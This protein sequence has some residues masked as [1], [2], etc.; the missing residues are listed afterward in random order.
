MVHWT[1]TASG[2]RLR[3]TPG[4]SASPSITVPSPKSA[5]LSPSPSPSPTA[6]LEVQSALRTG[7]P[8]S[9]F[10]GYI[11]ISGIYELS[12]RVL[13]HMHAS[14]LPG[15]TVCAIMGGLDHL[16]AVSPIRLIKQSRV[17]ATR[18]V[19]AFLPPMMLIH[20]SGDRSVPLNVAS[21]YGQALA[22]AGVKVR[23]RCYIGAT[24]TDPIIEDPLRGCYHLTNDLQRAY[25]GHVQA[26]TLQDP[27]QLAAAAEGEAEA[28]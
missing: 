2:G 1:R 6:L 24:H 3:W 9:R 27:Q 25:R 13:N 28:W 11:G 18:Q 26:T 5:G 8:V 21:E 22:A 7:F 19:T 4:L 10:R 14:G 16:P 17:R 15:A 12:R 20:G 23:F